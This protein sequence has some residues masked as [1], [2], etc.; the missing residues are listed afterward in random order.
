MYIA[1]NPAARSERDAY[2]RQLMRYMAVDSY[3][4]C[5]NNRRWPTDHG[6][7]TKLETLSR[8][9]FTLAFENSCTE[10]YVTEKF[11][12]PFVAGSVPV[13][14]GAP[15]IGAFAPGEQAIATARAAGFVVVRERVLEGLD[16]RIVVLQAPAGM[17]TRRALKRLKA[18]DPA[19]SY[20][21]NHV[22][23][24]H[25]QQRSQSARRKHS[26]RARTGDSSKCQMD[27]RGYQDYTD[28]K[29]HLREHRSKGN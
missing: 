4:R 9:P 17:S 12:D 7:A 5:L 10:D 23:M 1:S 8:Y 19:G 14:L 11:F 26:P 22:R 20:D 15:N 27:H 25:S 6:R 29:M 24:N 16:S 21:Y 2:V 3:G 18:P 28:H 13:Y